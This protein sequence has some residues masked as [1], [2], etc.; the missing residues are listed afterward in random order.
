MI[1][2]VKAGIDSFFFFN[3]ASTQDL[4]FMNEVR[5]FFKLVELQWQRFYR[6]F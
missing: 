3:Y 5:C 6:D 2:D 4:T 1:F